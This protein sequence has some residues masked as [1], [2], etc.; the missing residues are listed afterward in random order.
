MNKK[1]LI[2]FA[3]GFTAIALASR[4]AMAQ[5]PGAECVSAQERAEGDRKIETMSSGFDVEHVGRTMTEAANEH[6]KAME[7]VVKCRSTLIGSLNVSCLS[8]V[9]QA[10]AA[11]TKYNTA[12]GQLE[13]YKTVTE[14]QAIA[15][16]LQKPVCR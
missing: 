4:V 9:R 12:L 8:E 15:R 5:S 13:A 14:S 10:D 3:R 16:S 11:A 6:A 2:F 1:S 7:A